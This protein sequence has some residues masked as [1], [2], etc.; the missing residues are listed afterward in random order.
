MKGDDKMDGRR[1]DKAGG[2]KND[3][4]DVNIIRWAGIHAKQKI[5]RLVN[6]VLLNEGG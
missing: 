4:N 3:Y 2:K 6:I 1:V 5:K